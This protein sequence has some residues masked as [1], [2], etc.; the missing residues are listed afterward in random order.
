MQVSITDL[1]ALCE[2]LFSHLEEQ[3][4]EAIELTVDYYWE[5]PEDDRYNVDQKPSEHIVGQLTDDW[6]E[7]RKVLEGTADPLS[8]HLVW[9]AA[10]LRAI[11]EK[12]VK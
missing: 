4:I 7:L 11:G 1:R 2:R 12:I 9:L 6:S 10:I 3:R 5:V 8:Y